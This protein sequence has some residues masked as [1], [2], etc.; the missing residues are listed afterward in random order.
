MHPL[1]PLSIYSLCQDFLPQF[2]D[3]MQLAEDSEEQET[4]RQ[5]QQRQENGSRGSNGEY[6]TQQSAGVATKARRALAGPSPSIKRPASRVAQLQELQVRA[7]LYAC[8]T[9]S[10]T[11]PMCLT[12]FVSALHEWRFICPL[13]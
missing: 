12:L 9:L 7:L 2:N 13:H 4:H 10:F 11:C 3:R 5:Q 8:S 6:E 1:I